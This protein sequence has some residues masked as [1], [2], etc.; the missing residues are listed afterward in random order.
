MS[1][2]LSDVKLFI[3]KNKEPIIINI[4]QGLETIF[5][6]ETLAEQSPININLPLVDSKY[7]LKV[8]VNNKFAQFNPSELDSF[9]YYKLLLQNGQLV[10]GKISSNDDY[11]LTFK[12]R[13]IANPM[14]N[15][16][17]MLSN[18]QSV[19]NKLYSIE[20]GTSE[21]QS[22]SSLRHS[23]PEVSFSQAQ[24]FTKEYLNTTEYNYNLPGSIGSGRKASFGYGSK[25]IAHAYVQR[26]AEQNPPPNAYFLGNPIFFRKENKTNLPQDERWKNQNVVTLPGPASYETSNPV[27]TDKPAATIGI[28]FKP[29]TTFKDSVPAPNSYEV[30]NK[31][32]EQ[33]RFNKISFGYGQKI[34]FTKNNQT[35]GP[36]AYDQKSVFKRNTN[37]IIKNLTQ[38]RHN[39]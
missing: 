30:N 34:D 32:I 39:D 35:P 5:H 38:L 36:G 15:N 27:G 28:R 33:S 13:Q 2:S 10:E 26:N 4:S 3:V 22:A 18:S 31:L 21:Y 6:L 11:A 16:S 17:S 14:T 12:I 8:R 1:I 25:Q 19:K 20:R 7:P 37:Q 23:I 29:V 9:L 24:R